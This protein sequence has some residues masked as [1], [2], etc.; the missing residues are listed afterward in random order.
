MSAANR[1]DWL[2]G[3]I[4]RGRIAYVTLSYNPHTSTEKVKF[5]LE[6]SYSQCGVYRPCVMNALN[7]I[8]VG[9]DSSIVTDKG[10][11]STSTRKSVVQFWIKQITCN[12]Q[13]TASQSDPNSSATVVNDVPAEISKVDVLTA[14]IIGRMDIT[15]STP[16]ITLTSD[17]APAANGIT[18]GA[19]TAAPVPDVHN[20]D[21]TGEQLLASLITKWASSAPESVTHLLCNINQAV[22]DDQLDAALEQIKDLTDHIISSCEINQSILDWL[23]RASDISS[24]RLTYMITQWIR[25]APDSVS[26]L[27]S[28]IQEAVEDAQL[29]YAVEHIHDLIEHV[30]A[31]IEINTDILDWIDRANTILEV[32]KYF[33]NNNDDDDGE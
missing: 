28:N 29:D 33:E 3:E 4:A 8:K 26:H 17:E 2:I 25:S 18:T 13:H 23:G 31:T 6:E 14:D 11:A 24:R 22:G 16:C 21:D 9:L 20:T 12:S 1:L 19:D 5:T 7:A 15:S 27:V 30:T 32:D 10:H